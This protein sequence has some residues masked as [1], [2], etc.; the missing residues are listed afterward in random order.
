M[1]ELKHT[2]FMRGLKK[3]LPHYLDSAYHHFQLGETQWIFQVYFGAD[4]H[5]HYEVS[6]PNAHA[7][8]RLEVG[9]HFESRNSA[10]NTFW[11]GQL[12]RYILEIRAAMVGDVVAEQWDRGW[13]KLYETHPSEALL[14]ADQQFVAQ[15]LA[16]LIQTVQ[17]L[18]EFLTI[19]EQI[20]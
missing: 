10:L 1:A 8:R 9:L 14:P 12:S 4:K 19:Q 15:R 18:I 5:I 17:P 20:K 16:L 11:L 7:G 2:D 3:L 6:R 13:T